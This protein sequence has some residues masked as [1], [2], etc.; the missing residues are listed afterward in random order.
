MSVSI[1]LYLNCLITAFLQMS[2]KIRKVLYGAASSEVIDALLRLSRLCVAEGLLDS[3]ERL[4][5]ECLALQKDLYCSDAG[6]TAVVTA[7]CAGAGAGADGG[8]DSL[9]FHIKDAEGKEAATLLF[10]VINLTPTVAET[11]NLIACNY[12]AQG[13]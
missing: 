5:L 8:R 2:L 9:L 12:K 7:D 3:A 11:V 1:C 4:L 13:R 10:P 6:P